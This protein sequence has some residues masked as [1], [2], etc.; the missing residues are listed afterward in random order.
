MLWLLAHSSNAQRSLQL[1]WIKV[2]SRSFRKW[3]ALELFAWI[4]E[5]NGGGL[6]PLVLTCIRVWLLYS[7]LPEQNRSP[8]ETAAESVLTGANSS[9]VKTSEASQS[10]SQ[11]AGHHERKIRNVHLWKPLKGY[12]LVY[13]FL[14]PVSFLTFSCCSVSGI[15]FHNRK[16]T[17]C[18]RGST[19]LFLS[20]PSLTSVYSLP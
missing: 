9:G 14:C 18:K 17:I 5:G 1:R 7:H 16:L 20:S 13:F 6:S 10:D 4:C 3:T 19:W 11:A 15:F 2:G 8:E 12:K